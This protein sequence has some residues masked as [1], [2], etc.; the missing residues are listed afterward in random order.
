MMQ[1]IAL[2]GEDCSHLERVSEAIV[3]GKNVVAIVGAGI[4]TSSG[5]PVYLANGFR[6]ESASDHA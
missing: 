4:S 5:I 1:V 3:N 2:N 6:A